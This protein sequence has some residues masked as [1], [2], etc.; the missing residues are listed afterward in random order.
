MRVFHE[1][2]NHV[3]MG[4][5]QLVPQST[6]NSYLSLFIIVYGIVLAIF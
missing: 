5:G 3:H 6:V 4:T 2:P 1:N